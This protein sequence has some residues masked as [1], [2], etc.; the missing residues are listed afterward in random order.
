[1][2]TKLASVHPGEVLLRDFMEPLKLSAYRVAKDLGIPAIRISQIIHA[3]R[4]ISAETA[5][6]LGKYFGT[7]PEVWLRLQIQYDLETL[8]PTIR[9]RVD[10]LQPLG[11]EQQTDPVHRLL[12]PT[13]RSATIQTLVRAAEARGVQWR[14]QPVKTSHIQKRQK[15]RSS[16][17]LTTG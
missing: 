8:S 14:I 10:E 2:Q 1:M 13:N 9:K 12:A 11:A 4:S 17:R 3:K 15:Q 5:L 7:S 16:D 6:L